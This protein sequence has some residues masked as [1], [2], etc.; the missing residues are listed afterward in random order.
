M[1]IKHDNKLMICLALFLFLVEGL[2]MAVNYA[3][4]ENLYISISLDQIYYL[5]PFFLIAMW[6]VSVNF[7]IIYRDIRIMLECISICMVMLIA[8]MISRYQI[9]KDIELWRYVG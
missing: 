1:R 5:L 6:A 7:R 2:I 9:V 4:V 3:F 8:S